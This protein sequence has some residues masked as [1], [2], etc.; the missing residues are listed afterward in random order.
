[1]YSATLTPNIIILRAKLG[2][3]PVGKAL[4]PIK[5]DIGPSGPHFCLML[6]N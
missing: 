4:S 2:D 5:K 6:N 1:M 3:H